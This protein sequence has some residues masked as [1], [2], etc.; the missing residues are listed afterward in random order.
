MLPNGKAVKRAYSM[1]SP[2]AEQRRFQ[3]AVKR[4]PDG[5]GSDFM[6]GIAVGGEL[7]FSGPWG[8]FFPQTSSLQL[9]FADSRLYDPDFTHRFRKVRRKSAD[10][11]R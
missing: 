2:D 1:L 4:I 10:A 5:P 8:R 7:R 9:A 6:H 3:L 11:T